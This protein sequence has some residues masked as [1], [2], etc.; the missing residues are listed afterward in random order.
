MQVALRLI[1]YLAGIPLEVLV[2]AALLRVPFRRFALV[3]A[4][5]TAFFLATILE[6]AL[7]VTSSMGDRQAWSLYVR[8]YW[9]DDWVLL[10]LVFS[11]VIGFIYQA[12][13]RLRAR[14]LVRAAVIGGAVLF[15]AASF[16]AHYKADLGIGEWMTPWTSDLN[17]CAAILDL[18]LWALLIASRDNERY[19]LLLSGGLGVQF[20]GQ[21][22]GESIRHL[23]QPHQSTAISIFGGI[24]EIAA[25]LVFLYIW[26]Q[27][28]RRLAPNGTAAKADLNRQ[29]E[30][31]V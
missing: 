30:P 26:L 11:V 31:I 20:T 18:S 24:V 28:F 13:S 2:I 22:I 9:I 10:A 7:L 3:F 21:A 1:T 19:L 15:A 25:N 23:A 4:Y 29:R 27:A 17:F 8:C 12:T 16:L 5:M 14:R 6:S